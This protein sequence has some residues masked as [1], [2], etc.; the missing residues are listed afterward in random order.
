MIVFIADTHTAIWYLFN[1]RRLSPAARSA[2]ETAIAN[3]NQVGVSSIS[4]AEVVYLT[5]K[6]RIPAA[7]L[8]NALGV[9]RD[10]EQVL[11]EVPFDSTIAEMMRLVPREDVPDFPDRIV[12]ATALKYG[13]PVISRDGKIR[14]AKL[15]TIW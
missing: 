10:P 15:Q 1:D 7:T 14:A 3:G 2:F 11:T 12:A 6:S 4:L 5:E 8:E 13:V 9:L